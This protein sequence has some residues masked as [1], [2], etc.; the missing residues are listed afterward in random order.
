MG[1]GGGLLPIVGYTGRLHPKGVPFLSLQYAKGPQGLNCSQE[2]LCQVPRGILT[3]K[4]YCVRKNDH[5]IVDNF[6][7]SPFNFET[8]LSCCLMCSI[9][10]AS[11]L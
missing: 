9:N 5:L 8:C 6:N 10:K 7:T 3:D 11:L 2:I 1:G 4:F